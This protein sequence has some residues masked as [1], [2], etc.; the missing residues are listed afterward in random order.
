MDEGSIDKSLK[1]IEAAL[2]RIERAAARQDSDSAD[3]S[4]RHEG[5]KTAVFLSLGQLDKLISGQR[6]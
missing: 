6:R 2:A 3:L 1:R 4:A 5:L